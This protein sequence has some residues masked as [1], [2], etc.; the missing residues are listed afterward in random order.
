MAPSWSAG[1]PM[2][3]GPVNC[4]APYPKRGIVRPESVQVPPGRSVWVACGAGTE[5]ACA[6]GGVEARDEGVREGEG[7]T[8]L[9]FGDDTYRVWH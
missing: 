2:T 7:F 4:M 3:P 8:V 5:A 9:P 6:E 1:G